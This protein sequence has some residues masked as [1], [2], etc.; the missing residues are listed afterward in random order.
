[1]ANPVGRGCLVLDAGTWA[2]SSKFRVKQINVVF[3]ANDGSLVLNNKHGEEIFRADNGTVQRTVPVAFPSEQ[4]FD[5]IVVGTF[6]NVAK[7]YVYLAD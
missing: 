2:S 4:E 6:T 5:G 7:A 3:S 1:M